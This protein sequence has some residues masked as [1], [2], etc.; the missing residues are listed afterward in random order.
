MRSCHVYHTRKT[1]REATKQVEHIFE[2][3]R[4]SQN[5]ESAKAIDDDNKDAIANKS[6]NDKKGKRNTAKEQ[7]KRR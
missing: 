2:K 5:Q 7:E 3:W 1:L 6:K 4:Q